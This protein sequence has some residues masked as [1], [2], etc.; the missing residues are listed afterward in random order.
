MGSD[1]L[2]QRLMATF[3]GELEDHVRTLERELLALEKQPEPA[4]RNDL[5]KI[6]FRTAHSLKGAARSVGVEAIEAAG[7]RL[8]ELFASGRDGRLSIDGAYF[9]LILPTIDDIREA[10]RRLRV[11]TGNGEAKATV[12]LTAQTPSVVPDVQGQ[13]PVPA[14]VQDPASSDSSQWSGVV[15]VAAEKLDSLLAQ[16]G[17]LLVVRHR[18]FA[19][20]E[21]ARTLHDATGGWQKQW[22]RIEQR[23]AGLLKGNSELGD[24]A[25]PDDGPAPRVEFRAADQPRRQAEAL[26]SQHK[27]SMLRFARDLQRL[28]TELGADHRTL[29]QTAQWIDTEVHRVRMLPFTEACEGLDRMVRDLASAD[30]KV[31]VVIEAGDIEIDRSVLEGLRDPLLHL[32][33]NAVDHGIEPVAARRA[34][35]KPE[36]GRIT[37]A[38]AVRGARVEITV[39][40]D[41]RG[42]DLT[43]IR[44]QLRRQGVSSSGDERDVVEHIFSAGFSTTPAV[45]SLSGRGV[46]LEVVKTRVQSMRGGA[47]VS[48]EP[49]RGTKFTLRVPLTLTSVR[50][51][52]LEAG[53]QIFA[54]DSASVDRVLRIG[55][56]DV[57]SIEGREVV[58]LGGRPVAIVNLAHV[59]G[60]PDRAAP[61]VNVQRPAVIL[62]DGGRMAAFVV[63]DIQAEREV[64]VRPLGRRLRQVKH[65]A[66]ATV[67]PDGRIALILNSVDLA[68]SARNLLHSA[69][70]AKS[71]TV[72]Q[73]KDNKRLLL[74]DDSLTTRTLEQSILETAGYEVLVAADGAE[75]WQLLLERGADLVVSDVE[76]PRMD[77][78]SLTEAIRSSKQFR[79]LPVILMTARDSDADKAQG[80]RV[81]A[82]AYLFKSAFDQRELLATIG[83]I[84]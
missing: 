4:A 3:L 65:V 59:L 41:G 78:F 79:E 37:L 30:K 38:A 27:T 82:N 77:G 34:C 29:E 6:L 35:G 62:A 84:L 66:G 57:R 21:L 73:A 69:G 25:A 61:V 22:R 52:I 49:G 46:G 83:Q 31:E 39:S 32:V 14:T 56:G 53:H 72:T 63:D 51:L 20:A 17:E 18:A 7:H 2:T 45:T 28:V 58:M 23:F 75:A 50:V 9:N 5:F 55:A 60:I 67:L 54:I 33:R 43:A 11:G 36:T 71:M 12:R 13:L 76:M 40:D 44:A 48:F 10:G 15:R 74:V 64:V 26:L 16:S 70:V 42:L 81:G 8:E 1:R 80:L 24:G 68:D 19:R 47:D